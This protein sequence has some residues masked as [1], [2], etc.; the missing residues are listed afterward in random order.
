MLR[1][2]GGNQT[3]TSARVIFQLHM[4]T[5]NEHRLLSERLHAWEVCILSCPWGTAR[6]M[7]NGPCLGPLHTPLCPAGL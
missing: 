3:K 6:L 2:A 1:L 4:S 5:A 7:S